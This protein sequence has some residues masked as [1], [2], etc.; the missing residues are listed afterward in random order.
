MVQ[1]RVVGHDNA[2]GNEFAYGLDLVL[3]GLEARLA[4]HRDG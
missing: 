1:E 3:D 2:Y 4:A